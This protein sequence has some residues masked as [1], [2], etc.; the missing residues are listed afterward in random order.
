M[1][2]LLKLSEFSSS[3]LLQWSS[4]LQHTSCYDEFVDLSTHM[5]VKMHK[6]FQCLWTLRKHRV[7]VQDSIQLQ[8]TSADMDSSFTIGGHWNWVII[9]CEPM[10]H[11]VTSRFIVAT[12]IFVVVTSCWMNKECLILVKDPFSCTRRP[13]HPSL[14]MYGV[15]HRCSP[16]HSVHC[17]R[18]VCWTSHR[19]QV[20]RCSEAD[21]DPIG[22]DGCLPLGPHIDQSS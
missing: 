13:L 22:G 7:W 11:S 9:G 14:Q 20:I 15:V 8:A 6:L 3:I 19:I 17:L 2:D 4:C 16:S 21:E 10:H 1:Q 5:C 18:M 12:M